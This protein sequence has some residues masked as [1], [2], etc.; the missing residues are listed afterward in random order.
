ML[1]VLVGDEFA[2]FRRRATVALEADPDVEVVGE[3]PDAAAARVLAEQ[4]APDV[5][6]LGTRLPPLG[7]AGTARR[8]RDV[9]PGVEVVL[10]VDPDQESDRHQVAPALRAGVMVFV[11][12]ASVT[13][14]A[15][16]VVRAAAARRPRL[17]RDA[18]EALLA[19]TRAAGSSGRV[20]VAPAEQ[21]VLEVLAA[22]DDLGRAAEV[23]DVPPHTASNLVANVVE[24]LRRASLRTAVGDRGRG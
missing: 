14:Q 19:L 6:L 4:Y 20:G 17:D 16:T 24:K 13:D 3:A 18:A 9:L 12:R 11:P 7:G 10:A 15:L 21:V 22:G 1:R 2:I 23:L 5:A 8:L